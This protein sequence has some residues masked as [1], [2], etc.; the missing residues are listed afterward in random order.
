M[1]WGEEEDGLEEDDGGGGETR[2]RISDAGLSL[3][4]ATR[5]TGRVRAFG[6]ADVMD[7]RVEVRLEARVEMRVGEG[8]ISSGVFSEGPLVAML[9]LLCFR[10]EDRSRQILMFG[11]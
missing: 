1:S 7:W 10:V 5:R 6:V 4:T 11:E 9:F 3:E 8:H 2:A